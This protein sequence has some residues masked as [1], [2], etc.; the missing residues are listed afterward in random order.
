M[1]V[2]AY[3]SPGNSKRNH[4]NDCF[5]GYAGIGTKNKDD[6]R[7]PVHRY[8]IGLYKAVPIWSPGSKK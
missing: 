6:Q 3:N 4:I 7:T 5:I 1:L 2:R 8:G